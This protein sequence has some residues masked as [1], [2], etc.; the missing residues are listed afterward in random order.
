[1]T[2]LRFT[3]REMMRLA[4]LAPACAPLAMQAAVPPSRSVVSLVKG[5]SR[6]KN[7]AEALAAIDD[8][9]KPFIKRKKYVA[10]KVNNVSTTNQL[11]ASHADA[12][13]GILDYLQP[14]YK[15]PVYVTESS[16]GDTLK[17]YDSFKYGAVAKERK[18]ELI[19]LNR[20]GKYKIV[21]MINYDLHAQ[22]CRMAARLMDPDAYVIC[23]CMLKTHNVL[24]ATLSVKN[25]T[26]GAPL[27]GVN[28]ERWNDKRVVHNGLRQTQ[29]NV[30]VAAQ[31]LKP[32][33]GA[34]V[35][36][37]Y[38][39]MEGNGPSGGTPVPSRLAIAS[40]DYVAADRVGVE[41][42]G[43]NPDWM[44]YLKFCADFGIGQFDI[45]NIDIRGE[46]IGNV[47]RKYRLHADI[48][49]QLEWMGPL[50]ELPRKMG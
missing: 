13:H 27:H 21:P 41:T 22:P 24:V 5:E 1:M 23:A 48:E 19:D 2:P 34:T 44:G 46:A 4:A 3:R 37:A 15:K 18:I 42:M 49:R 50:K 47:V 35:I 31:A 12:I 25:M 29:Y 7:I 33:W 11:A 36:D 26:L 6:R 10:I 8:Q 45:K 30:F 40:T 14:R 9:I 32:Y 16:A 20:E 38:E 39:G 17:G 28:G 43:I